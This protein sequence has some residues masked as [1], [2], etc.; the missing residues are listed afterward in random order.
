MP[1]ASDRST[2]KRTPVDS[3]RTA[4]TPDSTIPAKRLLRRAESR[5]GEG[6]N[7][8]GRRD[9]I[10]NHDLKLA[11]PR[12]CLTLLYPPPCDGV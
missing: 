6:Y 7:R 2:P 4:D 12:G 9:E 11:T 3:C 10:T 1:S 5:E 8:A